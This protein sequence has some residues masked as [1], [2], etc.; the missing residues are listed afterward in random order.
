M[1]EI[2]DHRALRGQVSS[3]MTS[4]RPAQ[5]VVGGPSEKRAVR[6]KKANKRAVPGRPGDLVRAVGV[7]Q[8]LRD[9]AHRYTRSC[10]MA[11]RSRKRG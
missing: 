4:A 1:S 11:D 7:T 8:L 2:V 5:P 9:N 3:L 10:R 6:A